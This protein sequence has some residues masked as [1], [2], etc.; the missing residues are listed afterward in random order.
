MLKQYNKRIIAVLLLIAALTITFACN[1]NNIADEIPPTTE[2]SETREIKKEEIVKRNVDGS[3][4][5][6]EVNN[7]GDIITTIKLANEKVKT[8]EYDVNDLEEDYNIYK[9]TNVNLGDK[10][11]IALNYKDLV[12]FV[13]NDLVI[14][15]GG[16]YVLTGELVGGQIK[17]LEDVKE[18]VEIVLDNAKIKTNKL[19]AIYSLSNA[20]L[21]VRLENGSEN[22]IETYDDDKHKLLQYAVYANNVL[23]LAGNGSLF[24]DEGFL[25]A[26]GSADVLTFISGNYSLFGSVTA[27]SSGSCIIIK[28]GTY[29]LLS[30]SYAIVSVNDVNGFVY[31][32]DG[33]FDIISKAFGVVATN[34][35]IFTG[36]NVKINS[37]KTSLRGKTI[38][39]IDGSIYMKS[40]EDAVIAVDGKQNITA[41]QENVYIRF[42]G[43]DTTIDSWYDGLNSNGDLY[44]EGGKIYISGPTR[45]RNKIISYKGNVV[46]NGSDMIA[47]GAS[48]EIQDLGMTPNQSYIIVYYKERYARQKGSAYQV[49]D[50]ADNIL[51]SFTP[52]KDYR[53]A[54]ITSDKFKIGGTYSLISRDQETTIALTDKIT[55]IK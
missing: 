48:T 13:D 47:L 18:K 27:I 40:L 4:V 20:P 30:G 32:E 17:V 24:V 2:V 44:L 10:N 19:I 3:G 11:S 16:V 54:I 55:I 37:D 21:L 51:M 5:V 26:I 8:I 23:T 43:G 34:E 52:E 45:H 12:D 50:M 35:I 39:V 53:V 28:N 22:Y 14:K 33:E 38:D 1:N 25:N 42:A 46:V 29:N 6:S 15:A 36:G 41:V 31:I 7:D 49:R 9:A